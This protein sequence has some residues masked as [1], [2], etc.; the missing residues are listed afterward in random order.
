[1]TATIG[2][3][4]A[5]PGGRVNRVDLTQSTVQAAAIALVGGGILA[6]FFVHG[7]GTRGQLGLLANVT[8]LPLLGVVVH[9]LARRHADGAAALLVAA[10]FADVTACYRL[11]GVDVAA[12]FYF[13]PVWLLAALVHPTA[14]FAGATAA[15]AVIGQAVGLSDIGAPGLAVLLAALCAWLCLT[16]LRYLV[17][18]SW[19]RSSDATVL[20]EQ[21]RDRQ[22]DL[23][24]AIEALDLTNR[25]LQRSNHE[26]AVARQ[27]AEDARQIKEEFAANISHELRTP[28]NIIL[29]FTEIM[30]RSPGIYG[31]VNWPPTLRRDIAE[32]RRNARY[33]SDMVNDI[34]DLARIEAVRMPLRR[35]PAALGPIV[36]DAVAVVQRL[37]ADK[38]VKVAVSLPETLPDLPIDKVR[39]RQVLINLLANSSRFTEEGE[40]RVTAAL[41][42]DEV[43]VC[44]ADTGHG[45]A[46]EQL[47]VIFD[48][49][50]QL[51]VDA[52]MG[53]G[54]GLGLAIAKR[55]VQ[56]HGGSIWAESEVGAGSRFY[57]SLPLERKDFSRL[58]QGTPAP[59]PPNPYPPSVV[60]LDE[61]EASARYLGRQLEGYAVH[62]A[63][64]SLTARRLAEQWHPAA[65][66]V[67]TVRDDGAGW[68]PPESW[69][70]GAAVVYCA[71]PGYRPA[72]HHARFRA[73]LGKPVTAEQLLAALH[74][75]AADGDVMVVDD[76]RGFVQLL[77]RMLQESGEGYA[78][79][80]AYGGEEALRKMAAQK[81]DVVL[82][83]M[84]MPGMGGLDLAA[85]MAADATLAGVPLVAI[86]GAGAGDELLPADRSGFHLWKAGGLKERELL[87]LLRDCLRTVPVAYR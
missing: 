42:R 23:N 49:F 75:V 34:L 30:Y 71:L 25:L 13:A 15:L 62:W 87:G 86:S 8:L 3:R 80:W 24:R 41:R 5:G 35:E 79:R 65:V 6:W 72:D 46:P 48:E 9:R 39:I 64:D 70:E 32:I 45:I 58:G 38:P 21:L 53:G 4:W 22:G 60:V 85:A 77:L 10:I 57:F 67:N 83:D 68:A 14:A 2:G 19:R 11:L 78:V 33:L 18:W 44:V 27:E 43:V 76:D 82:L 47:G 37:L 26:L 81:P 69:P 17:E 16:P 31:G 20:T 40:I 51:E 61:G 74:G 52:T 7:V 12:F 55:F 28:L 29:G 50:R 84:V 73:W 54:K 66:V 59:L 36:D 56:L 63:K 1:M